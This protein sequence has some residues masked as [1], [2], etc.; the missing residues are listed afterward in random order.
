MNFASNL[1]DYFL[2]V[3]DNVHCT[4]KFVAAISSALSA[5]KELFWVTLEFSSLSA[6]G[7]VFHSSDLSR[8]ASFF[9]LFH[10]DTPVHLLLSEFHLLL[11]QNIPIRFNPSV[12]HHM[13]NY[14]VF[15][16]ICFP[17]EK[18]TVF[19][20]PDNPVASVLTDMVSLQ[21]VVPQYAYILNEECYSTLDASKGNHLTVI[22]DRPQKVIRIAVLTGSDTQ[23][24]YQL[25]Q[26]Q[27]ELGYGPRE[28]PEDCALYS[29]LGPL[30][31]GNLDQRVFPEGDSLEELSCIRLVVLASQKSWLLIRQIRVWTK[32]E[33]E[34]S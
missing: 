11:G 6:S 28:N 12:F 13:G 31:E 22:L 17:M 1:S 4:P 25:Q 32:P 24:S 34:E 3:E 23:G 30:V 14:S 29:L 10:Q 33:E 5:W 19:G 8:L 20:E 7:K 18:D 9:L 21:N 2:L 16:D 27:V 15:G 26:G